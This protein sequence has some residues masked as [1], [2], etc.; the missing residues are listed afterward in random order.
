M[1][2]K[3]L[4]VQ[5]TTTQLREIIEYPKASYKDLLI[6]YDQLLKTPQEFNELN[7][8]LIAFLVE[9]SNLSVLLDKTITGQHEKFKAP[10]FIHQIQLYDSKRLQESYKPDGSLVPPNRTRKSNG[11]FIMDVPAYYEQRLNDLLPELVESYPL[12]FATELYN[13]TKSEEVRQ[14][15]RDFIEQE[16]IAPLKETL[17]GIEVAYD[18]SSDAIAGVVFKLDL[19]HVKD[20]AARASIATGQFNR[21]RIELV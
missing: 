15:V 2:E 3:E 20:I 16:Y 9:K 7:N 19:T 4:L 17:P 1:T 21:Y 13:E 11:E 12:Q 8:K 18:I 10:S 6:G 14:H 5:L